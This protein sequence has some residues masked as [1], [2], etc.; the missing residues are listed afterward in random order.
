MI[1]ECRGLDYE[2]RL[3]CTGLISLDDRRTRGDL[4]QV[5]KL[6]KGF[7]RV[8]FNNFFTLSNSDKTRGHQYKI[9]KVRS[10]LELRRHFFSQRIVNMWNKLPSNVVETDSVNSFKNRLDRLWK[11]IKNN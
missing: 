8:D 6:I 5:F 4:I 7:D 9:V 10:R 3:E 2:H 11:I 1:N